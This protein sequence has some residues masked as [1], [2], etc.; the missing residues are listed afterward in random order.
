MSQ[1]SVKFVDFTIRKDK[2]QGL[3]VEKFSTGND[4]YF[5]KSHQQPI[6]SHCE[7]IQQIVRH[8]G[9]Q[10]TKK[11]RVDI[12]PFQY[13]Y[14]NGNV[15][16][17]K[18]C[19]LASVNGQIDKVCNAYVNKEIGAMKRAATVADTKQ[20]KKEEKSKKVMDKMTQAEKHFQ[21]VR[22]KRLAEL[23][24]QKNQATQPQQ[25]MNPS[26]SSVQI[27]PTGS[28]NPHEPTEQSTSGEHVRDND[29]D[30]MNT[31]FPDDDD[32]LDD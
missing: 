20:Q 3:L 26:T 17:F 2:Y 29:D 23:M 9:V 24:G 16:T 21:V 30:V 1:S 19:P 18:G 5:F 14:F 22:A 28:V 7:Q 12:G 4:E 8:I 10:R 6:K 27:V 31:S 11:V 25:S 32:D 15:A 13:E